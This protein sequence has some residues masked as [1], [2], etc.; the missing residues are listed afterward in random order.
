MMRKNEIFR[1]ELYDANINAYMHIDKVITWPYIIGQ[2]RGHTEIFAA[3]NFLLGT[4][5]SIAQ[6]KKS[7]A[8]G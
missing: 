8:L 5:E 1:Y 4:L 6:K 2:L 7:I 3:K